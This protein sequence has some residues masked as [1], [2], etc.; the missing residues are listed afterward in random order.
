MNSLQ[1]LNNGFEPVEFTDP[2]TASVT[3]NT[4]L[5]N[6]TQNVLEGQSYSLYVAR[7][8]TEIGRAHV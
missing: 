6:G 3:F 4:S 2:R 8:I 5:G 7:E 1:D